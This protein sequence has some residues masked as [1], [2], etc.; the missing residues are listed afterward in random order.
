MATLYIYIKY[1]CFLITMIIPLKP[2]IFFYFRQLLA[3][4]FLYLHF[5]PT[6]ALPLINEYAI[7]SMLGW[8]LI[9][10]M[11]PSLPK[12][13]RQTVRIV[14]L[15]LFVQP[16][17][18]LSNSVPTMA[19]LQSSLAA[20]MCTAPCGW[21]HPRSLHTVWC[22]QKCVIGLKV[23]INLIL[24]KNSWAYFWEL[25]EMWFRPY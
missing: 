24:I 21:P 2:L 17:W 12:L 20:A 22:N 3:Y 11:S 18:E 19:L 10:P 23:L 9:E 14:F 1:S 4:T 15:G 16:G 25:L 6:L 13:N 7:V 5:C 8:Q